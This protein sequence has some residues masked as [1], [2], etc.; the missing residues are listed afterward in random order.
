MGKKLAEQ[1][2]PLAIEGTSKSNGAVTIAT[3]SGTQKIAK[4][5]TQSQ[6]TDGRVEPVDA[7]WKLDFPTEPSPKWLN[8]FASNHMA[9]KGMN[10]NYVVPIVK[11]GEKIIEL[12][13][14]EVN[15]ATEEWKQALVIYVVG[16]S[17]TIAAIERYLATYMNNVSKPKIYYHNNDYLLVKF[18]SMDDRNDL[19]YSRPHILNNRPII[20][21]ARSANF[22]LNKEDIVQLWEDLRLVVENAQMPTLCMGDFNAM[23]NETDRLNGSPVQE[24]EIKNFVDFLPDTHM[25]ELKKNG[26]DYT[27]KN[28]HTCCRIDRAI[29]NAEWKRHMSMLEVMILTP[30]ISD[31]SPLSLELGGEIKSSSNTSK[32]FNCLVEH[33]EFISKVIEAWEIEHRSGLK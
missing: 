9:A 16:E 19:L 14:K 24:G 8:L 26:S 1:W 25:T 32:F 22:D 28:G 17:P 30:G 11:N 5:E 10:L 6:T 13:K 4:V 15:R 12:S 31:Y 27:W 29:V 18:A 2:P 7:Q 21:K 23:L 20:L 33:H 3:A